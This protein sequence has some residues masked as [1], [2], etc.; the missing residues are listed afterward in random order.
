[1]V[2]AGPAQFD[3]EAAMAVD[4]EGDE[5]SAYG[6]ARNQ[7]EA[8]LTAAQTENVDP[9]TVLRAVVATVMEQYRE[10]Y[11]TDKTREMLEFQLFNAGGDEEYHFMR[12]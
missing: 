9:E 2:R 1:M 12:P 11:G 5:M 7:V 6:I 3:A 8:A 10:R 4:S